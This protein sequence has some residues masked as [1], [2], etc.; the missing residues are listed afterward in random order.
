MSY[1]FQTF[2]FF[3]FFLF[4]CCSLFNCKILKIY[5]KCTRFAGK[6]CTTQRGGWFSFFGCYF[7]FWV[8]VAIKNCWISSIFIFRFVFSW[9]LYL[10]Y[11]FKLYNFIINF[12]FF[13]HLPNFFTELNNFNYYYYCVISLL[14]AFTNQLNIQNIRHGHI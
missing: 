8:F 7:F 9:I 12:F 1:H 2:F 3:F 10:S 6:F 4:C 11:N 5:T 13:F 14:I